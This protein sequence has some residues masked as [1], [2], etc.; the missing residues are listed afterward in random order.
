MKSIVMAAVATLAFAGVATAQE[1]NVNWS[2]SRV[3]LNTDFDGSNSLEAR[4]GVTLWGY[5]SYGQVTV[6]GARR[7]TLD[8]DVEL[9]QG[10]NLGDVVS[11]DATIGYTWGG[12]DD[13]NILGFGD[14]RTWGTV[15]AGAEL[16]V[17]PGFIGGEYIFATAEVELPGVLDYDFAGGEVGAGYKFDLTPRS[18][19]DASVSWDYDSDFAVAADRKLNLGVGFKF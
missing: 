7:D 18:Y 12:S 16:V 1:S 11:L 10:F 19:L 8:V 14:T 2:D 9:G 4:T 5:E 15:D 3:E 13:S 17:A 6:S